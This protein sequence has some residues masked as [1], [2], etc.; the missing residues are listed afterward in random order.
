MTALKFV[1]WIFAWI[2]ALVCAIWAAGA[3]Y[4]DFPIANF[5]SIAAILLGVIL[6]AAVIL[7]RG[8]LLKL[9]MVFAGF[10]LVT[11]WWF[12]LKPSNDGQWQPDVAEKGWAE[13]NGDE[14]TLHNVRNCDYR[15]ESDYTPRWETRAVRISQ[16]TGVDLAINYWGSPWMAHPIVSFQ[17]ADT[18]PICFSIE[19]R[20]KVGQTYSAI[21]G[22]YR[23]FAL[24]YIVADERDV[25]RVRTNYRKGEDVYLYHTTIPPAQARERFLEYIHS[26]NAMRER[27]RWYNAITTNCTTSIRTQR[28]PGQRMPWDWRILLNG[29]GDELMYERHLIVT[30]GLPFAELK[31]RS[32]INGRAKAANASPDFSLLIRVGLPPFTRANDQ[33]VQPFGS[34]RHRRRQPPELFALM[35][36]R[37]QTGAWPRRELS[38]RSDVGG[39]MSAVSGEEEP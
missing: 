26:L 1:A 18:P 23:Q 25:I 24:I 37:Y 32:L 35:S 13:I 2:I 33:T 16:I 20:K 39:Q 14:V 4:F 7:V 22:L 36:K 5:G 31:A 15:T 3:L 8:K 10:V 9:A 6:L 38:Q 21:G 29:K 11:A 17:F 28:P 27:P 30:G 19:T 12:T 34:V